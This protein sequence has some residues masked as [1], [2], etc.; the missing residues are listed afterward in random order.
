MVDLPVEKR[1]CCIVNPFATFRCT[2]CG[3][4]SCFRHSHETVYGFMGALA[5][6][7]CYESRPK[8]STKEFMSRGT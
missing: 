2:F 3:K 4:G 1:L 6:K 5:H 8:V 7:Q